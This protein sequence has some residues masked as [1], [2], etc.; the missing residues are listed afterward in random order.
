MKTFNMHV[1]NGD[2]QFHVSFTSDSNFVRAYSAFSACC[3]HMIFG[4]GDA[5]SSS[6]YH[7]VEAAEKA[8]QSSMTFKHQGTRIEIKVEAV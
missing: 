4:F 6:L 3:S 1:I 2:E 8:G 5:K 7:V